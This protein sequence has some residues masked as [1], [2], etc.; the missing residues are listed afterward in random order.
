MGGDHGLTAAEVAG[1]L[2]AHGLPRTGADVAAVLRESGG[3]AADVVAVV[4]RRAGAPGTVAIEADALVGLPLLSPGLV[5]DVLGPGAWRGLTASVPALTARSDGW[6]VPAA[7]RGAATPGGTAEQR[8]R[9]GH[10]YARHGE[11]VTA[12]RWLHA[13]GD[14]AILAEVL[15]DALTGS[16]RSRRWAE[17]DRLDPGELE[18]VVRSW[19]DDLVR[20]RPGALLGVARA[21]EFGMQSQARRDWLGRLDRLVDDDHPRRVAVEAELVREL[22]RTGKTVEVHERARRLRPRADEVSQARLLLAEALVDLLH[23]EESAEEPAT[24][25]LREAAALLRVNGEREWEADAWLS[26]GFGADLGAGRVGLAVEHMQRALALS[27]PGTQ[28]RGRIL[29]FLAE[30]LTVAGRFEE[31]DQALAEASALAAARDDA[32]LTAYAAWSAALVAS[33][34][35]D[36]ATTRA[37]LSVVESHRGEWYALPAGVAFHAEAA[38]MLATLGEHDAARAHLQV[39]RRHPAAADNPTAFALPELVLAARAGDP[40]DAAVL[41]TRCPRTPLTAWRISLL[42]AWAAERAGD[43]DRAAGLAAEALAEAEAT[44]HPEMVEAAEPELA[45]WARGPRA[46]VSGRPALRRVELLGTVAV[47]DGRERLTPRRGDETTLLTAVAARGSIAV[48]DLLDLMWPGQDG[49]VTRRRLRNTL[50][51]LR[52]SVGEVVVREGDRLS[53]VESA[54]VDVHVVLGA[55]RVRHTVPE[56]AVE[57]ARRA[58]A[59]VGGPLPGDGRD[60]AVDDLRDELSLAVGVLAD[61][62]ADAATTAGEL[63][64]AARWLARARPLDRYDEARAVR[65]VGVLRALGRHPEAEEVRRDAL[66]ACEELGVAPTAALAEA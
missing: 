17:L 6:F 59:L 24:V 55:A 50:N 45:T 64:E 19:P 49:T 18:A 28:L 31:T 38:D 2:A 57:A 23:G 34:R 43:A 25:M 60:P 16:D 40:A 36:V 21:V 47:H 56:L 22:A 7:D 37:Q 51:R 48:D 35:G 15:E 46:H 20:E 65:L 32:A 26:L 9:A 42:A 61:R 29:T 27:S 5:D 63:E 54:Q 11:L 39:G 53:L 10:W 58:L 12:V 8:L 44:G 13:C 33:R 4:R 14:G 52:G 66:A 62:V 41:A 1:L 3:G 30:A